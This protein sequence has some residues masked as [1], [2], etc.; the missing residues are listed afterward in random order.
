VRSDAWVVA[1]PVTGVV[2]T[3]IGWQGNDVVGSSTVVVLAVAG[4][5]ER[6]DDDPGAVVDAAPD[7]VDVS[8]GTVAFLPPPQ[9]VRASAAQ[10]PTITAVRMDASWHR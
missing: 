1:G 5:V 9:P 6:E 8:V 4:A 2:G 7:V 10:H 3:G